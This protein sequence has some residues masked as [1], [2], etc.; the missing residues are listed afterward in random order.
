MHSIDVFCADIGSLKDGS[1]D[2]SKF[3]WYACL[4]NGQ[5]DQGFHLEC[6]SQ[7]VAGALNI[8]NAVALGFEAPMFTPFR[9]DPLTLTRARRGETNPNWIGGPGATVLATGL[10]QVPW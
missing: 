4:G 7:A 1:K 9:K 2:R 10:A 3:G 8:G 5:T 6:L